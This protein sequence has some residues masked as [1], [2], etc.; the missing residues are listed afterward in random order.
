[1][2]IRIMA[3]GGYGEMGRNMTAV[4]SGNAHND[5]VVLDIGLHL[6]N[7]IKVTEDEDIHVINPGML[8]EAGAI[9][10]ITPLESFKKNI[11]AI[12]PS[13]AHLDHVGAVPFIEGNFRAPIICTNFT[14][15]VLKS[16]VSEDKKKLRNDLIGV[17]PNSSF[18]LSNGLVLEFVHTTHSTPQTAMIAVHMPRG[19]VLYAND[20]KFDTHPTLGKK[21]NFKRLEELGNMGV[22]AL[23]V[24]STYST[25]EQKMPSESVAKQLLED[26][27]IGMD[28][29]RKAI[30]VTTFSSHIARLRSICDFAKKINR[31]VV[32]MGRSMSRYISAAEENG[33]TSFADSEIIKYAVKAKRKLKRIM[34]D[35]KDKYVLIVTGHQGEPNSML[36]KMIQENYNFRFDPGD[37]VIFSCNVIPTPT[38]RANRERI[39]GRLK[40]YNV[41]FFKGIHVSGHAAKEDIRELIRLTKPEYVIPAHGTHSML[42]GTQKICMEERYTPDKIKILRNGISIHI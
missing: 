10:D 34:S 12:V 20:F 33:I 1:M 28:L 14:A 42:A 24:D 27:I 6:E 39:E 9:P 7:Y 16:I 22:K 15:S 35:G 17:E 8:R 26:V 31:K 40:D 30:I 36:S 37:V 21:P 5:G 19:I 29:R 25:L 2:T 38:N 11:S 41:R 4:F 3:I 32:I 13:H 23:I 18:K